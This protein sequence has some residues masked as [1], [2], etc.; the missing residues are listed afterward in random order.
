M[1]IVIIG[2]GTTGRTV[3]KSIANEGHSISI[4][5]EHFSEGDDF[6]NIYRSLLMFV[7]E[8]ERKN[9]ALRTGS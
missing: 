1:R 8:Q 6:A 3:L 7:A 9:S 2:L 5:D 4:I